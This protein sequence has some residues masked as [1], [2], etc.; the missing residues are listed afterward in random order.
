MIS[1]TFRVNAS[2]LTLHGLRGVQNNLRMAVA[3]GQVDDIGQ[4]SHG[5]L[6]IPLLMVLFHVANG[7]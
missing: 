4:R 5:F 3:F 6:K 7:S 2:K 1:I